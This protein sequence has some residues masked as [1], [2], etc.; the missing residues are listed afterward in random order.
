MSQRRRARGSA[1]EDILGG[2]EPAGGDLAGPEAIY[3]GQSASEIA[4]ESYGTNVFGGRSRRVV[5]RLLPIMDIV[6]DAAQPRRVVPSALRAHWDGQPRTVRALLNLWLR[7]VD[8]ERQERSR[9][10]F[11]LDAYLM[12]GETERA[13]AVLREDEAALSRIGRPYGPLEAGLLE[14]VD[15]AASI[16]RDGLTNPITVVDQGRTFTIETGERRWL[17]YHLLL[18]HFGDADPG[19]GQWDAIPARV[20]AQVDPWR[21]ASEN[22]AR[23]N[24]NAI[25][26]ARQLALLL[27]DLHGPQ[28]FGPPEAFATE[29]DFYAQVADG[30]LWR[31]P[32]GKGE[33]LLNAM[34]LSDP[35]QLR[36]YRALLRLPFDVWTYADDHN[37][38]E[39]EVRRLMSD[40]DT[41]TPVTVSPAYT[42]GRRLLRGEAK[43]SVQRLMAVGNRVREASPDEI[44]ALREDLD[45]LDAWVE[46]LRD[47][48][49]G[50]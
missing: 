26:R 22:S 12:G 14:V 3:G 47:A 20:V 40:E 44:E 11:D 9:P 28:H 31:V 35:A 5:A 32:R 19:G 48:L 29:Q 15:L 17:A 39:G 45:M 27:M 1:D 41:V 18:A 10:V 42:R 23:Q 46:S 37:L 7:Q 33:P 2:L 43:R 34:G 36:Q 30:H 50:R 38:S 4:D 13:P 25:A 24:L 6:P 16:R 8:R 21:Q 49:Y